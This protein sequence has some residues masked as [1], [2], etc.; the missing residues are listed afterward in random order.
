[1]VVPAAA[2]YGRMEGSLT[3]EDGARLYKRA[4]AVAAGKCTMFVAWH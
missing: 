3:A 4:A 2:G 1:M